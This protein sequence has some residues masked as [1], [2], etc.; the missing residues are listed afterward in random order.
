[1]AN[2]QFN[3]LYRDGGNYKKYH[4]VIFT[5]PTN[6]TLIELSKLIHSKLIDGIWFYANQWSLPD[7]RGETFNSDTD[8]TWHEFES[9]NYTDESVTFSYNIGQFIANII[10]FSFY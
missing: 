1:M 6:M 3:Y 2:I 10:P 7:L 5:N 8:P 9:I 4:S